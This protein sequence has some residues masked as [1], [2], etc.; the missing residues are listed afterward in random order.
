M[1]RAEPRP[2]G[3]RKLRATWGRRDLLQIKP[4]RTS[5]PDAEDQPDSI[6]PHA[7]VEVVPPDDAPIRDD[8]DELSVTCSDLG[9][10]WFEIQLHGEFVDSVIWFGPY[11]RAG[12]FSTV[13]IGP[14]TDRIPDCPGGNCATLG[15]EAAGRQ[16]PIDAE[17]GGSCIVT[18]RID[19]AVLDASFT[20][21]AKAEVPGGKTWAATGTIT[22]NIE[23]A[24][25]PD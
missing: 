14:V 21:A 6:T 15:L 22:C 23:P 16:V 9:S 8:L 1:G 10:Q 11:E 20:C 5:L 18:A 19:S 2:H 4:R 13:G 3:L 7:T 24:R 25:Q 12:D 17:E